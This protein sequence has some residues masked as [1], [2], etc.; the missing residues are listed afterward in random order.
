MTGLN[1][2]GVNR[3]HRHLKYAF[4]LHWAKEVTSRLLPDLFLQIP[5]CGPVT[6]ELKPLAS[7]IICLPRSC[8]P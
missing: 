5:V 3:T 8:L 6:M 2:A 4:A 7:L 1:D